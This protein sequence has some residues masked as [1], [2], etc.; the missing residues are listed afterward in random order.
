MGSVTE[1]DKSKK[2]RRPRP[3]ILPWE[4]QAWLT[5]AFFGQYSTDKAFTNDL[6]RLCFKHSAA[7]V[8]LD[9]CPVW[10]HVQYLGD[11][12]PPGVEAYIRDL[13]SL[14]HRWGLDCF[15]TNHGFEALHSWCDLRRRFGGRK[16][17]TRSFG[18]GTGFGGGSPEV[19]EVVSREV[20]EA[21]G[22]SG[23]SGVI[24]DERRAPIIRVNIESEWQ[25]RNESFSAVR[26]RLLEECARQ[27]DQQLDELIEAH[28]KAGYLFLD[29]TPELATHLRWLFLRVAYR[30]HVQTIQD[31]EPDK[32]GATADNIR[33]QTDKLAALLGIDVPEPRPVF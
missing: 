29:R 12:A 19:G 4:R 17:S 20:F 15:K 27:I 30:K 21:K 6:E 11:Q 3:A 24:V 18:V 9:A 16:V 13:K 8:T 28:E 23:T 31:D 32:R 26:A 25:A 7:L 22:P 33:K 2:R 5:V 14:A 1:Q 10:S